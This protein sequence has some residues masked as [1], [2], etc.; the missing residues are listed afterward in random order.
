MTAGWGYAMDGIENSIHT[1]CA[2]NFG[3]RRQ[4]KMTV[5]PISHRLPDRAAFQSK[6]SHLYLII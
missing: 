5:I 2:G 6:S 3:K 4:G 1:Q